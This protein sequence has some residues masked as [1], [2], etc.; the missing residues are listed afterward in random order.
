MYSSVA[1]SLEFAFM[2]QRNMGFV[3]ESVCLQCGASCR[4]GRTML[5]G[6]NTLVRACDGWC[7]LRL[8]SE[9]LVASVRSL[10]ASAYLRQ[11][12]LFLTCQTWHSSPVTSRHMLS[13]LS[14][15]SA[16]RAIQREQVLVHEHGAAVHRVPVQQVRR[17]RLPGRV[18][19]LCI[20]RLRRRIRLVHQA[21]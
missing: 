7:L 11:C 12:A 4:S 9:P 1:D 20:R 13:R 14:N 3:L 2:V 10:C 5:P 17:R 6:F 15:S 19:R 21:I 16:A 8:S 18:A